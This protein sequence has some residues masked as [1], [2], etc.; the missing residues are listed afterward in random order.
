MKKGIISIVASLIALTQIFIQIN[1]YQLLKDQNG[2]LRKH[3]QGK[4]LNSLRVKSDLHYFK[5]STSGLS[6]RTDIVKKDRAL[7]SESHDVIFAIHGDM[8]ALTTLL[9]DIS[10]PRSVNYGKHKTREEIEVITASGISH[11]IVFK[12]LVKSGAKI[13][14][15]ASQKDYLTARGSVSLW[16]TM[17]HTEFH[18]FSVVQGKITV[19]ITRALEY[20][21]PLEI[22]AH[23]F[24][25]FNTVQM[26]FGLNKN[27]IIKK[28]KD[29]MH[30]V[31]I[32]LM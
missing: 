18:T 3:R 14:S 24:S 30:E 17:F 11:D 5:E 16:E 31:K 10:D 15:D 9:N 4:S 29:I 13:I 22:H 7:H 12:Y 2:E 26:P 32:A 28:S 6:S 27:P 1:G 19:D 25:V 8:E 20:S 21:I 23:V